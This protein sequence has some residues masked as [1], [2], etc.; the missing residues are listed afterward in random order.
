MPV[1]GWA[2]PDEGRS[3]RGAGEIG[4]GDSP[5]PGGGV[6]IVGLIDEG[7]A[8]SR[9]PATPHDGQQLSTLPLEPVLEIT[10]VHDAGHQNPQSRPPP[11]APPGP[12]RL[13]PPDPHD[14][15][16]P[17]LCWMPGR[18]AGTTPT[19]DHRCPA[20]P[21]TAASPRARATAA[22]GS[23]ERRRR[24]SGPRRSTRFPC[25]A[26]RTRPS[27]GPSCAP[28]SRTLTTRSTWL[29]VDI[30]CVGRPPLEAFAASTVSPVEPRDGAPVVALLW[31]ASTSGMPEWLGRRR[32]GDR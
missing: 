4:T 11:C 10:S 14:L 12:A 32:P 18:T 9:A 30:R 13:Q 8:Y 26:T 7:L 29:Y 17:E 31:P 2:Q 22:S 5:H 25:T 27:S 3:P 23:R 16:A 21:L 28:P 1:G 19:E 24:S 20:R 15:G 6:A